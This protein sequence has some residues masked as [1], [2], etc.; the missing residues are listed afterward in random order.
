LPEREAYGIEYWILEEAKLQRLPKP[1]PLA[2]RVM[3]ITGAAGGIGR[4]IAERMLRDGVC[5]VLTD[6]D[7]PALEE[8]QAALCEK[9]GRDMVRAAVCDVTKEDRVQAAFD[10][11][12]L[13]Y[14]GLDIVVANAGLAT[15]APL[16]E[17]TMTLWRRNYEVLADGYFLTARAAFPLLKASGGSMVFVGSK[18][19]VAATLNA[20]AYASAKAA[21]L[22]LA[23]CLALEGGPFGVRV[24]VVNPDAVLRGSHIWNGDWRADRAKAYGVDAGAALEEHYRDRSLLKRDVLPEDVAE[25]VCFFASDAS[26]KSTGNIINVDSGNVQAF[27]R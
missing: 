11:A 8:V 27:T 16:E 5:V 13:E 3:L 21:A 2:G 14:G 19:A 25:A 15:S 24:N 12:A 18:N 26:S 4:A 1:K 23:R 17:T 20:S 9:Y 6:R 22:H 7:K 10:T